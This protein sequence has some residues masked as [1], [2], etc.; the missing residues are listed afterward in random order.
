[1][2]KTRQSCPPTRS[3]GFM[4]RTL[5]V[6]LATAALLAI[7]VACSP[8]DAAASACFDGSRPLHLIQPLN[9]TRYSPDVKTVLPDHTTLD[10]LGVTF[11]DTTLDSSGYGIAVKMY[12]ETGSRDDLCFIGG[13]I[14]SSMDAVNTPWTTW[15]KVVGMTVLTPDFEVVGTHFFNQGDA[16]AFPST[17]ATNWRVVGVAV[18]GGTTY[19]GGFIHDDCVENDSMN[20]GVIDDSKFDGCADFLSSVGTAG[21]IGGTNLVEVRNTLVRVESM[22]NSYDPAKYG[23]DQHGGF[24][25]WASIPSQGVPPQLYVHDSTFRADSPAVFAGNANGWLALPPG[26]RC[27]NVTLINTASWPAQDLASW[28][29]QCT[30]L[31]FG[32][33]ADWDAKV[34]AWDSA[35]PGL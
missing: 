20:A 35:H 15:H 31:T 7:A 10:A 22:Y 27:N 28:T 24:F 9:Q 17:T 13:S 34:A 21:S 18:D 14:I 12:D 25:K 29:S 16:I 2:Q 11:D 26:A 32:T 6:L 4:K 23:Y 1:M 8:R 5:P 33:T 19:D 30:N 3:E